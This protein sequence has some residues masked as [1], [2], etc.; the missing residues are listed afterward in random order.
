MPFWES[1]QSLTIFQWIARGIFTFIWLFFMTKIMGQR[2]VGRLTLFDFVIAITI[3]SVAAGGLNNSLAD[4]KGTFTSIGTLAIIDVFIAFLAMKYSKFRRIIQGEPRILIKNGKIL[5]KNLLK[6]RVNLDDLLMGLR[7][8]KIP[9]ISDVEFA[10][11]EPNGKMSVIP[12]SQSRAVKPKDLGIDTRYEGYSVTVIEDGNILQDNL[13][14][15][16]LSE[17]WLKEQIRL[18]GVDDLN[19][20]MAAILDTQGRLYI[21]KKNDF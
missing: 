3:G 1:Q 20:V 21:S 6:T 15:N 14:E 2:Q 16:N 8:N 5:D 12:K 10:I 7:R 11:L 19:N 13:K 9:N 4:L 18:Q 17:E